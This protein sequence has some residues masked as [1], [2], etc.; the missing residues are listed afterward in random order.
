MILTPGLWASPLIGLALAVIAIPVGHQ[1]IQGVAHPW[2]KTLSGPRG[3]DAVVATGGGF[4]DRGHPSRF[5]I[6]SGTAID[7]FGRMAGHLREAR[8]Q[9]ESEH[10]RRVVQSPTNGADS[11]SVAQ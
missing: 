6:A 9:R 7:P 3:Q 2:P 10:P 11:G 8:C 5:T 4:T 1:V